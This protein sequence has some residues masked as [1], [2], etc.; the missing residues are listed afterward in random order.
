MNLFLIRSSEFNDRPLRVGST[1]KY[2]HLE[3]GPSVGRRFVKGAP[4][5]FTLSAFTRREDENDQTAL[6][7]ITL[8]FSRAEAERA[9]EGLKSF[10][11]Q[12]RHCTAEPVFG[13]RNCREHRNAGDGA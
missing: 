8:S 6:V 13:E 11:S 1:G 4:D 7:N 12:C 5:E 9:I 10:L 3:V 2:V